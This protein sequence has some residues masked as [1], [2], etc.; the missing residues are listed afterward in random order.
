MKL[1]RSV[2]TESL[3]DRNASSAACSSS[4]AASSEYSP[5]GGTSGATDN[6]FQRPG[7][8][9]N[10]NRPSPRLDREGFAS[11]SHVEVHTLSSSR[12]ART[13]ATSNRVGRSRCAWPQEAG[14]RSGRQRTN[15]GGRRK[16]AP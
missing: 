7:T 15:R 13:S 1:G 10:P 4:D 6:S 12:P 5:G 14:S 3:G 9:E 2:A 8:A 16:R 11:G